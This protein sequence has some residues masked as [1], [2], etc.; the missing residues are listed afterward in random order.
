MDADTGKVIDAL[1]TEGG[2]DEVEYD[3]ASKRVY[4]TGTTGA[5]DV[6]QQI[7]PDHYERLGLVPSGA[8]AKTSL[9]V[10]EMQ[11]FYVAV[12]KHV[13]LTPPLPES[14]EATIEDAK[15]LVYEV[16]P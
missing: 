15:I 10:R 13:I 6:F 5:V 7:D 2:A 16:M 9:L 14:K 11:R 1:D 8:I 12:P 4:L 3:A